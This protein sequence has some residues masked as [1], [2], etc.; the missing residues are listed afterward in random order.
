MYSLTTVVKC[1]VMLCFVIW[2]AQFFV[3]R[4][5]TGWSAIRYYCTWC[6]SGGS[7]EHA[8]D[9]AL[10]CEKACALNHDDT[11]H[12]EIFMRAVA[13]ITYLCIDH[14]CEEIF[15]KFFNW[16]A[17]FFIFILVY[18]L[19]YTVTTV[20]SNESYGMYA[21]ITYIPSKILGL[22]WTILQG[23]LNTIEKSEK[24]VKINHL[25]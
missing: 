12:M 7:L 14:P 24:S 10:N 13:E 5:I 20:S 17:I 16:K 8:G 6:M 4:T 2:V 19:R 18:G 3:T 15:A 1:F 21:I 9:F 23:I 25:E 22:T 11:S